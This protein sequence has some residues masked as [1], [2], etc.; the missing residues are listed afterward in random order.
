ML[1]YLHWEDDCPS[2]DAVP[3]ESDEPPHEAKSI[4]AVAI[5]KMSASILFI[6]FLLFHPND[7]D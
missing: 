1:N 7:E 3:F 2:P 6:N 4:V 5:A